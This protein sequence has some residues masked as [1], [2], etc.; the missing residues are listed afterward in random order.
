MYNFQVN[1][2][3]ACEG[4]EF[5]VTKVNPVRLKARNLKTGQPW[6]I[7][8]YMATFLRKSSA[9]DHVK[10]VEAVSQALELGSMVEFKNDVY[11]VLAL[12]AGGTYRIAKLGGDHNRYYKSVSRAAL[13]SVTRV[14]LPNLLMSV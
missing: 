2:I 13:K 14:E 1:D 12:Q 3:I 5:M 10:A 11:V 9:Y 8:K 4:Q 7:D 6:N